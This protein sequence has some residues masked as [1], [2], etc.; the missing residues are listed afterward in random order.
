MTTI[1]DLDACFRNFVTHWPWGWVHDQQLPYQLLFYLDEC[2]K[3]QLER[4]LSLCFHSVFPVELLQHFCLLHFQALP[5]VNAQ[6]LL[7]AAIYPDIHGILRQMNLLSPPIVKTFY[8]VHDFQNANVNVTK[9]ISCFRLN[10]ELETCIICF[11]PHVC[12][13]LK[14]IAYCPYVMGG[15]Q[16]TW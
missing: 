13:A 11:G 6:N 2:S 9:C 14:Q 1:P 3:A 7:Q 10:L 15:L 5:L 12:L 8:T 4:M 16:D